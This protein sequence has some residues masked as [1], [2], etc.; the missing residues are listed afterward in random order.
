MWTI[1]P[2]DER[3]RPWALDALAGAWGSTHVARLGELI[4]MALLDG[5]VAKPLLSPPDDDATPVGVLTYA[6]RGH[7]AEVVSIQSEQEGRGIGQLLMNSAR[8]VAIA[9]GCRRLW[10]VTTNDNIRAIRFYQQ[11]GMD[12]IAVHRNGVERSRQKKP[13]IPAIGNH[14]IPLRHE[15]EFELD[16]TR[17]R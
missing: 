4:D 15:L 11:W 12:L 1:T 8:D 2:L 3:S 17:P 13:T 10:L 5:F 16:L 7:D 9:K 6:I 14:G